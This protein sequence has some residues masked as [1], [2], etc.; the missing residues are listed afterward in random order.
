[1]EGYI[2][3]VIGE[4]LRGDMRRAGREEQEALCVLSV[5]SRWDPS[6]RSE[7]LEQNGQETELSRRY[8]KAFLGLF[9]V[10][11]SP[12][13]ASSQ[14]AWKPGFSPQPHSPHQNG[15]SPPAC[16]SSEAPAPLGVTHALLANLVGSPLPFT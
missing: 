15:I 10:I 9:S 5:R 2:L 16:R 13:E 4:G 3:G 8:A 14:G 7:G 12:W 11:R 1:M 6:C